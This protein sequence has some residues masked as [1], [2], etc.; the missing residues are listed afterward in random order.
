MTDQLG[1]SKISEGY[2]LACQAEGK[3][4]KT[5]RIYQDAI[6]RFVAFVGDKPIGEVTTDEL[7]RYFA[8]LQTTTAYQDHPNR[9]PL[10][11]PLSAS[12]VHIE[13]RSLKAFLN[14][15]V[16]EELLAENPISRMKAPKTPRT[17]IRPLSDDQVRAF[18]AA[19]NKHT[20]IGYRNYVIALLLLDT[21][22]RVSE[23]VNIKLDDVDLAAQELRVLGK[24]RKERIV[25]FGVRVKRALWRYLTLYRHEPACPAVKSFFLT[26]DGEPPREDRVYRAVRQACEEAGIVGV[27]KSPHT[28]RHTF[29]VNFLRNGGN[30]FALQ[31]IM[32]HSAL[33]TTRRY[34]RLLEEDLQRAHRRASP[35]DNLRL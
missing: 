4:A 26:R 20:P 13:Y 23:V 1:I 29:A 5:I 28:L 6:R 17:V 16:R 31:R 2:I 3:S 34:V 30:V 7:R 22:L 15:A 10:D 9:P 27:R 32:G 25:P 24:G 14:W 19:F 21:G 8:Q 12:T 33:E 35:V 18:L 11:R